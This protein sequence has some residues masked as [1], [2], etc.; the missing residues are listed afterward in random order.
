[1]KNIQQA[2]EHFAALI[3]AQKKRVAAMRAEGDFIDYSKLDK[4]VIGVCGGDGIGPTITHEAERVLRFL[5]G[6]WNS[7]RSTV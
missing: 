5:L 4:L 1:M 7:K 2:Q 6:A 3:E